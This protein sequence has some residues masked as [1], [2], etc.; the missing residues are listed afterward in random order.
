MTHLPC[1]D[2]LVSCHQLPP[3]LQHSSAELFAKAH[4]S[5]GDDEVGVHFVICVSDIEPGPSRVKKQTKDY[6]L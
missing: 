4:G 5:A 2:I 3:S 1:H 6:I